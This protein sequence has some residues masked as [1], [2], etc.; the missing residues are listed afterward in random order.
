MEEISAVKVNDLKEIV[1]TKVL[2]NPVVS[3]K[4]VVAVKD[5]VKRSNASP[6][7][8][9]FTVV[10]N[11]PEYPGGVNACLKFIEENMKYPAE[12]VRKG[13]Q[14]RAIIACVIN[15]DGSI[16]DCKVVRSVDP[17]LDAEAIRIVKMMPKWKPGMQR[18]KAVPVKY[19]LPVVFRIPKGGAGDTSSVGASLKD[20]TTPLVL[21]NGK[22]VPKDVMEALDPDKIES[23]SVLKGENATKMYGEKGKNG[24]LSITL[25][26]QTNSTVYAKNPIT[27]AINVRGTV[28]DETGKPMIGASVLLEGT[29]FGTISD[30]DGNFVINAPEG[31]T[32]AVSYIGMQSAKVKAGPKVAVVLNPEK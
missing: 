22:E 24:V 5:T 17:L 15:E 26:P 29:T 1:E 28:K 6:E 14:G 8:T 11:M 18:G 30:A 4:P 23:V 10:E 32:L 9:V 25:K 2:E 21:V 16:S 3:E 12:A 20:T 13:I 7:R 31:A 19:T 27:D